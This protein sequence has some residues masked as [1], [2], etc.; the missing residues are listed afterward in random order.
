MP[1]GPRARAPPPSS[2]VS[3]LLFG[4]AAL[5]LH[6][7]AVCVPQPRASG[8]PQGGRRRHAPWVPCSGW[9]PGGGRAAPW[10]TIG[11]PARPCCTRAARTSHFHA[12]PY[13]PR[14]RDPS[15]LPASPLQE[16]DSRSTPRP[17][18]LLERSIFSDR[19]VF[20]R[21]V[22]ESGW[23]GDVEL[24]RRPEAGRAGQAGRAAG[25]AGHLKETSAP[26]SSLRREA[27]HVRALAR[28]RRRGPPLPHGPPQ[29]PP[30]QLS[31]ACAAHRPPLPLPPRPHPQAV[32][33]SWFNP[34]LDS[35]PSLVP[36]GFIY[37]RAQPT[38]CMQR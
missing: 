37:L 10:L 14:G 21:A 35:S 15:S 17:L 30:L 38:T 33:D 34:M 3:G 26:Q 18:R 9:S 24:V 11:G 36:D 22:R 27:I 2:P 16:R 13:I 8:A 32:Y 12:P 6:L 4:P 28:R 23:M 7:P 25:R 29:L 5:R 19:M 31:G 1:P 20:V